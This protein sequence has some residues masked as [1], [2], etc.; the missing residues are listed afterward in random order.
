MSDNVN[1]I[2]GAAGVGSVA[3]RG[4]PCGSMNTLH[5]LFLVVESGDDG[6]LEERGKAWTPGL[7]RFLGVGPVCLFLPLHQP[8]SGPKHMDNSNRD[9]CFATVLVQQL[10][11]MGR[12]NLMKTTSDV[13][14]LSK[15]HSV[16][17]I[18]RYHRRQSLGVQ[19]SGCPRCTKAL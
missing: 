15:S 10:S 18:E 19:N 6:G 3:Q 14:S 7:Y 9:D 17:N 16:E 5:S 2:V 4:L 12:G 11:L 13:L 1:D 8:R